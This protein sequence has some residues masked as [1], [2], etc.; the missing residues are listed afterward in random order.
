MSD[1]QRL[2]LL[3]HKRLDPEN[4]LGSETP[5]N[6]PETPEASPDNSTELSPEPEYQTRWSSLHPKTWK[7]SIKSFFVAW[8]R[9]PAHPRDD[10]PKPIGRLRQLELLPDRFRSKVLP[11][12]RVLVF[13]VY[14]LIWIAI[15]SRVLLPYFTEVPQVK[16]SPDTKVITLTCGDAYDFWEGKNAAC[17]LDAK[18][19]PKLHQDKDVIIRCPALCDRG[20]WLYSLRAVGDQMIKYRGLF[21]GGGEK[22]RDEKGAITYPYRADS[23]PCGAGVHA[24]IISPFSGGCAKASFASGPQTSFAAKKGHYGVSDSIEFDAFFPTSYVFTELDSKVS[25]CKDP[26]I[27]VLL[28]N[29]I[30]GLPIVVFGSSA[31]F[32]WLIMSV[33][34]WTITLATD[35]PTLVDP[36]RPETFYELISMSLGRFLPTCF[37]MYFLWKVSLQRTFSKP[38]D[39]DSNPADDQT[40]TASPMSRLIFW[41]PFFWLGVLNNITFDRLPVDRLTWKDL[42]VQPGAL[43]TVSIFSVIIIGCVITQAYLVW[44]SGRFNKLIKLYIMMFAALFAIAW[45]PGLTLRIHHYIFALMFIPGCSTR[46]RTAYVFQG[47]L[48][49]LFLS[50]VA[51]WGY[52]SIAETNLSLLRGEPVGKITPPSIFDVDASKGMIYWEDSFDSAKIKNSTFL[53]QELTKYTHVSLLVNDVERYIDVNEG[54]LNITELVENNKYLDSL[55]KMSLTLQSEQDGIPL[56]LRLARYDAKRNRHGDYTK[57]YKLQYPSFNLTKAESGVT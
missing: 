20:S 51:R 22:K 14:M 42:Q 40:P 56:Y 53:T 38:P 17:G 9:G 21:I 33:G 25:H 35:P 44:L 36:A 4:Q 43:L 15:W 29:I 10:P 37:V 19:C 16:G 34:F 3:S 30:L 57:A 45:I 18:R 27:V 26:R 8:A 2:S 50:G 1:E 46:G 31:V 48:L 39:E 13:L 7:D 23:F 24:G 49:G 52:A 47:L 54:M 55:V 12:S 41:Y 5:D 28:L 6:T 11:T 32:V